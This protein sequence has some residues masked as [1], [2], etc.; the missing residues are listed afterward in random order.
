MLDAAASVAQLSARRT[1]QFGDPLHA[2]RVKVVAAQF[3]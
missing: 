3:P 1:G 2:V